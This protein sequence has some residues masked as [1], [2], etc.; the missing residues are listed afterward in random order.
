MGVYAYHHHWR[1]AESGYAD[2]SLTIQI[3]GSL[4]L[5]VVEFDFLFLGK[6]F[7]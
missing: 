4:S 5:Y 7:L 1:L 3:C 6:A 2:I